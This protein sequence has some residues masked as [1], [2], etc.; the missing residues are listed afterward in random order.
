MLYSKKEKY[1][2]TDNNVNICINI[3]IKSTGLTQVIVSNK[4]HVPFIKLKIAKFMFTS[5]LSKATNVQ[6][7]LR[8]NYIKSKL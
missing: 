8:M 5:V 1:D 2:I 6:E 4:K 7:Y 3:Y